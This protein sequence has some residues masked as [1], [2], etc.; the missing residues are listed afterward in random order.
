M[1]QSGLR[2]ILAY[3][4]RANPDYELV[5]FDRL[6][7]DQKEHLK[8]FLKERDFYG[9][10][11]PR[12]ESG[13]SL[14]S[15]DRDTALLFLTMRQ[16]GRLPDYVL[17]MNASQGNKAVTELVLAGI[18]QLS[19]DGAFLSAA[20]ASNLVC[21]E[22]PP[23]AD[24]GVVARLSLE[25]LRYAQSLGLTDIQRLS[26]RLYFYNRVPLSPRW[27]RDLPSPEAVQDYLGIREGGAHRRLLERNWAAVQSP[28]P[29]DAWLQFQSRRHNAQRRTY[30]GHKL[31][32]S[33]SCE[34][35]P[36]VFPAVLQVLSQSSADQ[37]K[38]G[39]DV[40]GLLRPD[41]MVAYFSTLEGL[42]QAASGLA[43][44][45]AGCLAQGVPFTAQMNEDGL[46]SRGVDP[47]RDG[48]LPA[49][50]QHE[51]WRLWVTNR[52]ATA[53]VAAAPARD[54]GL[55]PW[56]F[57]LRRMRLEGVDPATWTPMADAWQQA[58]SN[59]G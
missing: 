27:A 42:T 46:I 58:A 16:P 54:A 17:R 13:L 41:K 25:A 24:G 34:D 19:V 23:P 6:P 2:N 4:F 8:D 5:L 20:A 40:A 53:L 29:N 12:A 36:A 32:I 11:R 45:L 49:W 39:R 21:S 26:A 51:S 59:Q 56:Q 22:E 44:A 18:L 31:Y 57:A 48:P 1:D 3:D 35:L 7:D 15:V 30:Y 50:M 38:I 37:F 55:E 52:L 10:L 33:P 9:F 28:P 14:K 47:P 43:E